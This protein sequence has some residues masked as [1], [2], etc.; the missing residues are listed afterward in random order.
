LSYFE[1]DSLG[2][3]DVY[4]P[5]GEKVIKLLT[6]GTVD[7]INGIIKLN[8]LNLSSY[9]NYVSIYCKSLNKDL[10]ANQNKI[11]LIESSD[12]NITMVEKQV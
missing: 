6:I 12:V 2:N 9:Q 4:V 7:Y 8:N 11:I 3:I 1:D 5:S 10:Y